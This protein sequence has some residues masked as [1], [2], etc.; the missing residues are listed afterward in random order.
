VMLFRM[1]EILFVE[2]S[3][4]ELRRTIVISSS[5][6]YNIITAILIVL[7]QQICV[8]MHNYHSYSENS[9]YSAIPGP[10]KHTIYHNGMFGWARN[11]RIAVVF[12]IGIVIMHPNANLLFQNS[13]NSCYSM[14]EME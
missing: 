5:P 3:N 14:G 4:G 7:E 9:G 11:S 12:G 8:W 10:S 13:E 2:N 1:L 6:H